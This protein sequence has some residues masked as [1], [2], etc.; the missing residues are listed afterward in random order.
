M[1][2][3]R[4]R[5]VLFQFKKYL[6]ISVQIQFGMANVSL[7]SIL[8]QQIIVKFKFSWAQSTSVSIQFQFLLEHYHTHSAINSSELMSSV[9]RVMV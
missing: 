5:P 7:N 6:L 2:R 4:F 9:S 1:V 3:D 8:V